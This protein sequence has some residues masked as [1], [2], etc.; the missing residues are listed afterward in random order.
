MAM[1]E[2]EITFFLVSFFDEEGLR[3]DETTELVVQEQFA[4]FPEYKELMKRELQAALDNPTYPWREAWRFANS[5]DRMVD[6]DAQGRAL[7]I[8]EIWNP[9]FVEPK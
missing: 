8:T 6:D 3:A 2:D 7:A 9:F 5:A 4:R 1:A